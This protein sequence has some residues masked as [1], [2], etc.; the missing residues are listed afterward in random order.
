MAL[1]HRYSIGISVDEDC[2]ASTMYYEAAAR[3][4]VSYIE[5]TLGMI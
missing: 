5:R 1:G 4:T 2:D 3:T